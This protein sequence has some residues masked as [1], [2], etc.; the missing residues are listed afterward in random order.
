L[1]LEFIDSPPIRYRIRYIV[2]SLL[3]VVKPSHG[4]W[5][6]EASL[7]IGAASYLIRFGLHPQF[8]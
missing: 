5:G 7:C 3:I 6:R 4:R 1:Y 2:S 8:L